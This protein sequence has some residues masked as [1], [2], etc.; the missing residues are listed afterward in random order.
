MSLGQAELVALRGRLL[1]AG[2]THDP[3]RERLTDAGASGLARNSTM[4]A[5]VALGDD[6][7]PQATLIR[8]WLLQLPV[9]RALVEDALGDLAALASAGL[10]STAGDLVRAEAGLSPYAAEATASTPALDGWVC[11][12][13]TPTLD[14]GSRRVRPDFVLGV[15]PASTTLAQLTIRT[16]VRRALDLGTGCGVQA[17]HLAGH[18]EEVV[19]TDLN[20]RALELA[21]IT[22]GLSLG[23]RP[24]PP[25]ARLT[26][27]EGLPYARRGPAYRASRARLA[28]AEG[29]AGVD[30]RRGSLWE[31]VAEER[32]DLI[33]T[34]PPYVMSPPD[35]ERLTYREGVLPGDELVR[36]VVTGGGRRL[37]DGGTMQ[38]LANWAHVAGEPWQE[39]LAAWVAPTGCDA[40]VLQRELLDPYEYIELWLADAGLTGAAS[41]R[42]YAEW[43]AY[44][45]SLGIIGVGLGWICLRNAGR[46]TPDVRIEDWPHAVH[47]PVGDA[48]AAHHTGVDAADRPDA[49]LLATAWRVDRRV[50]QETLGRPGAADP[51]HVILRQGY[52]LGRAVEVDTALAAVVGACDGDLT[53]GQLVSAVASLL[54]VDADGLAAD[55]VGRLR[56]LVVEGY[57]TA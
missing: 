15:S 24:L 53:A 6:R 22:L 21:R 54:D 42:H 48:F 43:L 2:Y 29:A 13:L 5:R 17:L 7:D 16:P 19:A 28:P 38:V 27:A 44:F 33:V 32:F 39:R 25:R 41:A 50:T 49:D 40:L 31:P 26:P 57:L 52:G 51:E 10:L 30:L 56:A 3:V 36:Q 9:P 34:N 12:D 18:A 45:H 20:P 8:L 23:D 47:Q 4:P 37:A 11:H 1:G 55:V 46:G 35:G 14:G